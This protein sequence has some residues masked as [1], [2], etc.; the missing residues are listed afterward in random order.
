MFILHFAKCANPLV[1]LTHKGIPFHFRPEQIAAQEDLKQA[2]INSPA[3]QP[4]DYTS[5]SPVILAVD[6]SSIAVGFY[7]CQADTTDHQ[8]RFY[9][10]FGSIS[11][12]DWEQRFS[13]PKL[14]LYGLFRALR[15]YKLFIVGVRNL[16]VEVDARYIKGMLNNPDA[17]PSASINRWIVSILAFHFEL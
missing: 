7:L 14:E 6:T 3:L 4:I 12:N 1:Y 2:L 5:E 9:A 17:A 16:I 13:Q 15:A 10:H 8:R 11:L